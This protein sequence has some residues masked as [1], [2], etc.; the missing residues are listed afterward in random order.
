MSNLISQVWHKTRQWFRSGGLAS[1]AT[2]MTHLPILSIEAIHALGNEVAQISVKPIPNQRAS[3]A[4]KQGE[5]ASRYLGTGME[6]EE[7]RPYQPGDEVRR[8]NWR[9]MAR[10]GQA[11]T[12]LFQEERQESWTVILDQRQSM[13]FGT[14]LRLKVT[15][16]A[17]V[18]GYFAWQAQQAGLPIE[19]IALAE[20][21]RYSPTFEGRSAFE[22]LMEFASIPCPPE[23]AKGATQESR[24]YDELL[25]C[26]QQLQA[27][28][29]LLIISD[30][31][32]LDEATLQ[33]LSALQDKVLVQAV[34]IYDAVERRL[35]HLPGLQLQSL[36]GREPFQ[37]L[38]N[39][40][41]LAYESWARGYFDAGRERLRQVGVPVTMLATDDGLQ[42]LTDPDE[43]HREAV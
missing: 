15:Q 35:P 25:D 19:A 39:E 41:T 17:R 10:T 38:S 24:L 6:Y 9:L 13:R 21:A 43:M 3:E 28:A 14:R 12:K 42:V 2:P 23:L 5:Q 30:F 32:D 16:A 4:R 27:G 40:Q 26:Q 29:R 33:L 37:P 31:H 20:S 22:Q 36:H 11:Y 18:A 34:W 7:S 1:P 8:I